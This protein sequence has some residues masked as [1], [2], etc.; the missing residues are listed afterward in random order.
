[1][2]TP[3]T[4]NFIDAR[5]LSTHMWKPPPSSDWPEQI[6]PFMLSSQAAWQLFNLDQSIL[7]SPEPIFKYKGQQMSG[8]DSSSGL[9]DSLHI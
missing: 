1:M 5:L 4:Q 8:P 7:I 3:W 6:S 9:T 2:I